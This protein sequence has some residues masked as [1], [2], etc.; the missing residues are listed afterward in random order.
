LA[1]VAAI[2]PAGQR[3]KTQ[4]G[5][6][7]SVVFVAS[8]LPSNEPLLEIWN[9]ITIEENMHLVKPRINSLSIFYRE[10]R[11]LDF[12]PIFIARLQFDHN[13]V[14]KSNLILEIFE[15]GF[16]HARISCDRNR[17]SDRR[18]VVRPYALST[19]F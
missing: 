12:L 16:R 8:I 3:C 13:P 14:Y 7:L 6:R 11:F 9:D 2:Q 5:R 19:Q 4:A 17:I 1:S 18:I 10:K 15:G